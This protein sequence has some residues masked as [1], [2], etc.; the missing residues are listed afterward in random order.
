M[1]DE[2]VDCGRQRIP[3]GIHEADIAKKANVSVSSASRAF[4]NNP[5]ISVKTRHRIQAIAAAEGYMPN[6]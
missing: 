4:N 3:F 6:Y 5:R 2:A 1:T